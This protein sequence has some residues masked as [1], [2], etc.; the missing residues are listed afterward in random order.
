MWVVKCLFLNAFMLKTACGDMI[1]IGFD[2]LMLPV[3]Q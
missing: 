2:N 3:R 1:G